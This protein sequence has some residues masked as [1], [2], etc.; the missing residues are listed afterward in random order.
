MSAGTRG[1]G[2]TLV[3]AVVLLF[4]SAVT[5]LFGWEAYRG[6]AS[7]ISGYDP[8]RVTDE[9]ALA[10]FVGRWTLVVAA[11]TAAFGVLTAFVVPDLLTVVV[12]VGLVVLIAAWLV[13]GV[14]RFE[15]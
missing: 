7:L 8:D 12:Y 2:V 13:V 15:N 9:T 10:R 11:L 14:R 6:D 3:V 4:S 5:A 1:D